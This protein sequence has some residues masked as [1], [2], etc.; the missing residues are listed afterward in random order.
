MI[1]SALTLYTIIESVACGIS[2]ISVWALLIA[3]FRDPKTRA[4]TFDLYLVFC[5]AADAIFFPLMT[6]CK[7]L[8]VWQ[9]YAFLAGGAYWNH[10]YLITCI[11]SWDSH[12]W[13]CSSLWMSFIIFVQI[14]KLLVSNKHTKRY[15]P[16]TRKQ[17]IRDSVI[18]HVSSAVVATSIILLDW[19]GRFRST[20]SMMIGFKWVTC[21]PGVFIPLLLTTGMCFGVWWNQLLP[22]KNARYRSLTMFFARL[23][24][25][26]YVVAIGM[27]M[28]AAIYTW[29]YATG[30]QVTSLDFIYTVTYLTGFIQV[31]LA[32][33][34]K[35][36]RNAFLDMWCYRQKSK[37][38]RS[39]NLTSKLTADPTQ[40]EPHGLG[41][42]EDAVPGSA[43]AH[44]RADETSS[45]RKNEN[46]GNEASEFIDTEAQIENI[47]GSGVKN[48]IAV[49]ESV[50]QSSK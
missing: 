3:I 11:I 45:S 5:F 20:D 19:W 31:C 48:E 7:A 43:A 21:I 26:I 9:D 47:S 39:A 44:S 15:Q 24:V 12:Y 27:I 14:Y 46:E 49:S 2:T 30:A 16:P 4:S 6:V 35:E 25:S 29:S 10:D 38:S 13:S 32:L 1:P 17:V 22:R 50:V 40:D 36:L 41:D 28:K 33:T 34:K 42:N 23:L 8:Y 18:V 37:P